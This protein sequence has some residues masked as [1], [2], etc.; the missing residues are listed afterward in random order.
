M[1]TVNRHLKQ[2]DIPHCFL[3]YLD[4]EGRVMYLLVTHRKNDHT[5][6]ALQYE[7]FQETE[8][9]REIKKMVDIPDVGF[10]TVPNPF[11]Q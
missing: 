5:A 2:N 10:I 9:A 1:Y 11:D 4:N 8:L 3:A 6:T 7:P